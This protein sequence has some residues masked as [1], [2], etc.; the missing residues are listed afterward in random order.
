M[1][2][3]KDLKV[4][5]LSLMNLKEENDEFE[6]LYMFASSNLATSRPVIPSKS[7]ILSYFDKVSSRY[8]YEGFPH[9]EIKLQ[10]CLSKFIS[11]TKEEVKLR[12]LH[13]LMK[14]SEN[15]FCVEYIFNIDNLLGEIERQKH[16]EQ[17]RS[18]EEKRDWMVYLQEGFE[19]FQLPPDYS[20]DDE[21]EF[22]STEINHLNTNAVNILCYNAHAFRKHPFEQFPSPVNNVKSER[23]EL[24]DVVIEANNAKNWLL[25]NF[26]HSWWN[27]SNNTA[28]FRAR[29]NFGIEWEVA[30]SEVGRIRSAYVSEYKILRELLWQARS[31]EIANKRSNVITKYTTIPSLSQELFSSLVSDYLVVVEKYKFLTSFC[32]AARAN[33]FSPISVLRYSSVLQDL[34][35]IFAN[36]LIDIEQEI[37]EQA[38]VRLVSVMDRLKPQM[39]IIRFLYTL[40]V[41]AVSASWMTDSPWLTVTRILSVL[42]TNMTSMTSAQFVNLVIKL[43]VETF[44]VY[45]NIIDTWLSEGILRDS[46]GEFIITRITADDSICGNDSYAV[47]PFEVALLAAKIESADLL[48]NMAEKLII[49]SYNIEVLHRLNKLIVLE[50]N[51]NDKGH[52]YE[53]FKLDLAKYFDDDD[54]IVNF[55]Y[56]QCEDNTNTIVASDLCDQF[57]STAFDGIHEL[58][59]TDFRRN[60]TY[61]LCC[62]EYNVNIN[63][64]PIQV[65]MNRVLCS[66]IESRTNAATEVF[67]RL[68]VVD[69]HLFEHLQ[70]LGSF[71]L[72]DCYK[73][74]SELYEMTVK[75]EPHSYYLLSGYLST[76]IAS[77]KL[78]FS[79]CFQ[80]T[81]CPH[82]F[83]G[84]SS[85]RNSNYLSI[86]ESLKLIDLISVQYKAPWPISAIVTDEV[87]EKYYTP[88][89]RQIAKLS[90]AYSA[91]ARY[92]DIGK[93]CKNRA[94]T[95]QLH[96]LRYWILQLLYQIKSYLMP[97]VEYHF[98][99]HLTE[100]YITISNIGTIKQAYLA[101]IDI[102]LIKCFQNNKFQKYIESAYTKL[103]NVCDLLQNCFLRTT[104]LTQDDFSQL[105]DSFIHCLSYFIRIAD[106][107]LKR[108]NQHFNCFNQLRLELKSIIEVHNSVMGRNTSLLSHTDY[109]FVTTSSTNS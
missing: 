46:R 37:I 45:I 31:N 102:G 15:P 19:K 89:F 51:I 43:F 1:S 82:Q 36:T 16:L 50:Q 29:Y 77:N 21:D 104:E 30:C 24:I 59:Q 26:Q 55:N 61:D 96:V 35:R 28:I 25:K 39:D 52:L 40:H 23:E 76:C 47:V 90:T 71:L 42:Y 3:I 11:S 86:S 34:C 27:G 85:H 74:C 106:C 48:I 73:F 4:L 18:L 53:N 67:K 78:S 54:T 5:L 20:Q 81:A 12:I 98:K 80:I 92:K 32:K 57:L 99:T 101:S 33:K 83:D 44:S 93:T 100:N 6:R 75:N 70:T 63:Q 94:I 87:L 8:N 88:L 58:K 84:F 13:F 109:K 65:I 14:S 95:R 91:V 105:I 49:C 56:E 9:L 68:I 38:N 66:L 103:W 41:E 22:S 72:M 108:N 17:Q 2:E 62:S 69:M 10:N 97:I 79:N 7:G 60:N 64:L 107:A